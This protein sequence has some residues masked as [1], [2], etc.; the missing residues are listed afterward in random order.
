VTLLGRWKLRVGG[1]APEQ[2][3]MSG[4]FAPSFIPKTTV[5]QFRKY[6]VVS[7]IALS[8]FC[9]IFAGDLADLCLGQWFR[10]HPRRIAGLS[11]KAIE[12]RWRRDPEQKQFLIRV[13]KSVPRVLGNE[14]CSALFERVSDLVEGEGSV[15]FEDVEGLVHLEV[16]VNRNA[17]PDRYLLGPEG[18]M[19]RARGGTGLDEDVPGISEVNEMLAPIGA[20]HEPLRGG[21]GRC[22]SAR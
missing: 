7:R 3:Q 20:E 10:G 12:A 4:R 16:A 22:W 1:L 15:A 2:R 11:E 6:R 13:R 18:Q 17:C 14:D 19:G 21:L 8:E 5:G 9:R